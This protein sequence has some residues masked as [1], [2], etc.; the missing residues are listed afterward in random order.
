MSMIVAQTVFI[1]KQDHESSVSSII[2]ELIT[3]TAK[4]EGCLQYEGFQERRN[5]ATFVVLEKWRDKEA[6]SQHS[7]QPH[8][9]DSIN[10]MED[11]LEKP[12][13]I[14]FYNQL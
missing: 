13:S 9:A 10:K 14:T 11:L 8:L 3:E 12:F 1:A 4:E 5:P 7:K 6:F 2:Q